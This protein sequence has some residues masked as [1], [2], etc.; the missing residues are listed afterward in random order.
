[1]TIYK[2]F[3][4]GGKKSP[5]GSFG[6]II[7]LVIFLVMMYFLIKGVFWVLSLLTPVFLICAAIFDYRVFIDYFNFIIKLLKE[8]PIFGIVMILVTI[9]GFPAVAGY[10]FLKAWGRKKVKDYEKKVTDERNRF[11]QYEEVKEEKEDDFLELPRVQH[12]QEVRRETPDQ[13]EYDGLFK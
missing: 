1:M 11:D 4:F 3:S 5:F 7:G 10:L 9:V 8:N 12:K 2:E 13:N 6:A